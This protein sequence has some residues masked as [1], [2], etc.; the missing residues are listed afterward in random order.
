MIQV[1]PFIALA[2]LSFGCNIVVKSNRTRTMIG[3]TIRQLVNNIC[4]TCQM[5]W[6]FVAALK[7]S[8]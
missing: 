5:L 7:S 6:I 8:D 4:T 1:F 2:I 3:Q